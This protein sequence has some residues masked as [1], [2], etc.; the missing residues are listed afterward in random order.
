MATVNKASLRSE[1]D[2]LNARFE[3]LCAEGKMS[4]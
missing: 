4:A 3:P 2:A 1:F